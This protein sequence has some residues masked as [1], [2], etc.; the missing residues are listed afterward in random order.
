MRF[1]TNVRE[2]YELVTSRVAKRTPSDV[3]TEL[4]FRALDLWV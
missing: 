4:W 3:E 2:S 1:W